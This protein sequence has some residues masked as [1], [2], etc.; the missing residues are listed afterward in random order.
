MNRSRHWVPVVDEDGNPSLPDTERS[1]LV[2]LCGDRDLT[3]D[4]PNDAG[5]GERFGYFDRDKRAWRVGGS[6]AEGRH[7]TH[8][9]DLPDPPATARGEG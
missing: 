6:V 9:M 2:F 3:A 5:W 7:V 8:W 1:V 4:R